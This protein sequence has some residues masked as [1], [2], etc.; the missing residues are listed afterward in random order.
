MRKLWL[1][2]AVMAAALAAAAGGKVF[3]GKGLQTGQ[4]GANRYT[5]QAPGSTRPLPRPY[6]GAPPLIPH[7]IDGL[8]VTR[9]SNDCL[10]C[11]LDGTEVAEGHS[12]TK[13]PASHFTNPY[14]QETK[15]GEVVGT[16]YNCLQCHAPQAVG[17][18]PPVPQ[19]KPKR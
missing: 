13:V 1:T 10:S 5:D 16:R 14:T 12:A 6:P 11:H 9:A 18:V 4:P 19:G 2:A 7:S 15:Q 3:T 17:A 8:S